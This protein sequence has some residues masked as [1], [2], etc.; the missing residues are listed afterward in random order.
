MNEKMVEYI[1]KYL[2]EGHSLEK[3]RQFLSSQ[4]YPD[5]DIKECALAAMQGE[6][7]K[8]RHSKVWIILAVILVIILILGGV[9]Y[10]F[11]EDVKIIVNDIIGEKNVTKD[12]NGINDNNPVITD[13]TPTNNTTPQDDVPPYEDA[14]IQTT[15]CNIDCL[16]QASIT[17]EPKSTEYTASMDFFGMLINTKTYYEMRRTEQCELYMRTDDYKVSI[18]DETRQYLLSENVTEDEIEM[19]ILEMEKYK[20]EIIGRDG[21]C[22]F[23]NLENMK[24]YLEKIRDGNFSGSA[25]CELLGDCDINITNEGNTA[26]G[27]EDLK[28][29]CIYEGDY[30]LGECTGT[31]F[32]SSPINN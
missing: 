32:S 17:C 22:V 18:T 26:N 10:Y 21:I 4:G 28:W 1:R 30:N 24:L 15:D 25:S 9:G 27:C 13:D 6:I 20:Y 14:P 31:M 29:D 16:I 3:I 11:Q 23:N 8:I 19:Q 7:K 5:K 2:N 12:N